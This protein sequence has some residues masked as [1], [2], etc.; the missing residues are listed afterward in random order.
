MLLLL[1]TIKYLI[2]L[3]ISLLQKLP[4]IVE[5]FTVRLKQANLG[6]KGGIAVFVK[7]TDFDDALK[8]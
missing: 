2:I 4:L 3:N 5:N 8:I 6:N 7:K 1:L